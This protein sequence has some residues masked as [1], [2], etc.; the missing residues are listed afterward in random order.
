VLAQQV[1]SSEVGAVKLVGEGL[2]LLAVLAGVGLVEGN[3]G[4]MAG[5]AVIV[6][7]LTPLL[8]NT[9]TPRV[10]ALLHEKL[11]RRGSE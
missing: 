1:G 11:V 3:D 9:P 10:S 2:G 6:Q 8:A 5:D 7:P 4:T